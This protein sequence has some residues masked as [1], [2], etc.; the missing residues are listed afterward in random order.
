[1]TLTYFDV[2]AGTEPLGR[3]VFKLYDDVPK[4]AENFRALCTGEKGN[5]TLGLPLSYKGSTFH[6]IIKNFMIQGGDFTSA[7]RGAPLGTGGESIYGEKFD[8]E[9]FVHK[10]DKPF[11]LSMANSGPNTNGSQ[12]FI[13]TVP[14]PHL[15]DKHVVFGEVVSG[16]GVARHIENIKTGAQDAPLEPVTIT[17]CGQ[18]PDD[19]DL[20]L[21]P[22]DGT[23][24]AV[25]DFPDDE[26]TLESL[27]GDARAAK[28]LEIAQQVKEIG[29]AQLK[30]K[31]PD[32]AAAKYHK[33][34]RYI[35]EC[36]VEEGHALYAQFEALKVSLYLNLALIA[37]QR[38][39]WAEGVKNTTYVLES[40]AAQEKD[41]AKAYYRR[42]LANKG[43]RNYE[44]AL[45]D[46]TK[47][48]ELM[49]DAGIAAE[50]QKIKDLVRAKREKQKAAYS[51]FF[52]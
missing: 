17:D 47:A 9:A 8:D 20:S 32:V 50:K 6:R 24:D 40:S 19:T 11:L 44:N 29:T 39:Q 16:K 22:D 27:E 36:D 21:K 28:G 51:K 46:L 3:I 37:N 45:E 41:K 30:Q 49:A 35:H 12:F 7:H 23:G 31:K 34:L 43:L 10:H 25:A 33:A 15:D 2:S 5:G 48:S 14:T 38:Q 26:T 18:L 1:M 42:A 52:G 4:T 13:T